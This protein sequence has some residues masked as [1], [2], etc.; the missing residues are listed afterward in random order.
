MRNIR[1]GAGLAMR[2]Q[3]TGLTRYTFPFKQAPGSTILLVGTH[4]DLLNGQ[5][6]AEIQKEVLQTLKQANDVAV[7]NIKNEIEFLKY[8]FYLIYFDFFFNFGKLAMSKHNGDLNILLLS[9]LFNILLLW[10][11]SCVQS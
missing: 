9:F 2:E 11:N 1:W 8:V 10:L 3:K 7:S 6:T 4:S 5:N